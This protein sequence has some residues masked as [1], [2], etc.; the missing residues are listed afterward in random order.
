MDRGAWWVTARGVAKYLE[1]KREQTGMERFS[2]RKIKRER[3]A[4][5]KKS[6][7][8]LKM[9]LGGIYPSHRQ[10]LKDVDTFLLYF[11]AFAPFK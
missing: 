8:L 3:Q 4:G 7:F 5:I 1:I 9:F 6:F 2:A 10:P 11:L